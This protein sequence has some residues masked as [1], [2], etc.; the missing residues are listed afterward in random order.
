MRSRATNTRRGSVFVLALLGMVLMTMVVAS[1][2]V[3]IAA[4]V[5]S[6]TIRIDRRKAESAAQAGIARAMASLA[7]A[8]VNVVTETDEW[9][10]LGQQGDELFVIGDSQFRIEILDAGR[11]ANLNSI[12]TEQ[13]RRMN[14]TDDVIESILDWREEQLQ[15]RTQGAKDEYYNGLVNPYNAKLRAFETV[16]EILLVK[17]MTPELLYQP[18]QVT[19]GNVLVNGALED[20]P[21]LDAL[22][23]TD[24]T[25]TNN[26]ADGTTRVNV[27]TV[28]QGQLV[29]A[30]LS[31][32]GATAI[33]NR[34]N[35]QGTFA[36][37]S[38]VLQTPGLS[39]ADITA[40]LNAL[41][42]TAETTV[43]GKMNLNTVTEPVLRTIPDLTDDQIQSIL[44]RQ[45]T[46]AELG[47]LATLSGFTPQNVQTFADRFT[48]SA[49][50][51]LV[52][53]EGRRGSATVHLE[54][55][56]TVT[57][58]VSTLRKTIRPTLADIITRWEWAAETTTE[59]VL[60]ERPT[61]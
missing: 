35:T 4:H 32:Q 24:S 52:R 43:S 14:L 9:F 8:N 56:V 49:S 3:R 10:D 46:F 55:V 41:T 60:M 48:V 33:I 51:F 38:A 44:S 5:K 40:V 1:F 20:Q 17:G 26:R 37:L 19:G 54:A 22:I 7:E 53:V 6:E 12:D 18:P 47:D 15:P 34:R 27:N 29:T 30:G 45:P 31:N 39:N 11:F 2:S 58:G 23:T 61:R 25:S 50:S 59:T 13:M 21:A 57:E 42:V 28:N 36:G 16:E